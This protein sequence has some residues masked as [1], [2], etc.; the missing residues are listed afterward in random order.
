MST[1]VASDLLTEVTET[2]T[3]DI[4]H[5]LQLREQLL[6]EPGLRKH[7]D[8]ALDHWSASRERQ[9]VLVL[10]GEWDQ[11]VVATGHKPNYE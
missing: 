9:G 11:A 2:K 7:A 3:P 4:K 1:A 6:A 10:V 5:L 8:A